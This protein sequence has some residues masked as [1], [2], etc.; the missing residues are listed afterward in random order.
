MGI[1]T[2]MKQGLI[3]KT[4]IRIN[5][6][7]H[8]RFHMFDL[9]NQMI[10]LNQEVRLYTAYPRMKLEPEFRDIAH[11]HPFPALV[12]HALKQM[13]Y[14]DKQTWL[15]D[16]VLHNFGCWIARKVKTCDI[17]D[18]LSGCGL[19][20]GKQVQ[21]GGGLWFCNSGSS[22]ILFQ[23]SILEEE[24]TRWNSPPLFF[25]P[26]GVERVLAEYENADY[27][28]V[29]SE[30]VRRTFIN[31]GINRGKVVKVPF[32]VSLTLFSPKPKLD[33]K[34]R[35]L[36]V[37]QASIRKGIGYLFQALKPLVEAGQI[38]LW[39]IG[40]LDPSAD[41]LLR[42]YADI[43][44]YKGVMPR[45]RLSEV[46]SQGSALVLPSVEEGLSL[47][48]AQAM[49]CS[50]PVIATP[51][52]GAEDL[53]TNGVEG[54]VVPAQDSQAI[55]ERVEY[56]IDHPDQREEMGCAALNRVKELGGWNQY[57]ENALMAYR[58]SL[59]K[60]LVGVR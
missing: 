19:D 56:L 46:Y 4:I 14:K 26:K 52:T 39:L 49:A 25:S 24:H 21:L 15:A 57:G 30:F 45:D 17:F 31:Q 6:A 53:F 54:F 13:G 47:V 42:R 51:N 2:H 34:F 12:R 23:K 28:V 9:A 58:L 44:L 38:E 41:C 35:I 40:S 22:H 32:G 50:L 1:S 36:F 16:E 60:R 29:P 43:F 59:E 37:G 10:R 55:R 27:I 33:Q 18:A 11:T 48:Q 7:S 5:I 8:T 20:A 3:D